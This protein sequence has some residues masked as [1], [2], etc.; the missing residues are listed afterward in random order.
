[1]GITADGVVGSGTRA[2]VALHLIASGNGAGNEPQRQAAL[3]AS[4]YALQNGSS[5]ATWRDYQQRMGGVTVD[6]QKGPQTYA[7]MRALLAS[8]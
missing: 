6:G 2:E 4:Y 7:R 1:M 3:E 5:A 8:P